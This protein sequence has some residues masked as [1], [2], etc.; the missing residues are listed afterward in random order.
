MNKPIENHDEYNP[1][2]IV[3][4]QMPLLKTQRIFPNPPPKTFIEIRQI[5]KPTSIASFS[6]RI[7]LQ[8]QLLRLIDA[9]LIQIIRKSHARHA[10]EIATKGG[11]RK[12]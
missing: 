5:F 3:S 12:I 2:N 1:S 9:I 7:I 6:N 10:F 11:V 4:I 8:Q